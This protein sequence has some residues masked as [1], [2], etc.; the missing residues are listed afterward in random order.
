MYDDCHSGCTDEMHHTLPLSHLA[1]SRYAVPQTQHI[2]VSADFMYGLLEA[3]A[4]I[5]K[6]FRSITSSAK[7]RQT[8][9]GEKASLPD[10]AASLFRCY[11]CSGLELVTKQWPPVILA[12]LCQELRQAWSSMTPLHQPAQATEILNYCKSTSTVHPHVPRN[13]TEPRTDLKGAPCSAPGA[14]PGLPQKDMCT[15]RSRAC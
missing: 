14:A 7:C 9:L 11:S 1:S 12:H 4:V 5:A 6:P 15:R 3:D 8:D 2:L 13:L 10:G